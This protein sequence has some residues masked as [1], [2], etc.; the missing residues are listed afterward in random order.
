[1]SNK[2]KIGFTLVELLVVIAIIGLL[3]SIVLVSLNSARVK[4]RDVR[5]KSD[6]H[7]L[8]LAVMLYYDSTGTYPDNDLSDSTS[9]DWSVNFKNQLAPYLSVVPRDPAQVTGSRRYGA[10]RL[11]WS[12][13]ASCNGQ[14]V[15]WAILE[16]TNDPDY[17]KYD[18]GF[19]GYY[20]RLLGTF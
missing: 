4:A 10:Y 17:G 14:Y 12:T 5:R 13:Q 11:T 7:S 19:A 6:L 9:G 3:A 8:E 15:L 1:M 2:N 16:R 18:C 20:F